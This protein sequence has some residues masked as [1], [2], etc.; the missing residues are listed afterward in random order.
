MPCHEFCGVGHQGM[1]AHVKVIDRAAFM[2][3]AESMPANSRRLSCV[4]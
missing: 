1:W 4:K 2:Q 3:M